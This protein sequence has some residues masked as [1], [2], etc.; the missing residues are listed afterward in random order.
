MKTEYKFIQFDRAQNKWICRNRRSNGILGKVTMYWP[1]RKH[2]F[3][4]DG[5]HCIFSEDCLADIRHFMTELDKQ[6][7]PRKDARQGTLIPTTKNS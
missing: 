7:R 4:A 6:Q 1:W 2:V 3:T 5:N